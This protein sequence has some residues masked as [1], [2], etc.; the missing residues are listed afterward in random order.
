M[1]LD[2][3]HLPRDVL[4]RKLGGI[5]EIY[6][7]F[8]GVD[9]RREAMKIFPAVH[10]SMGGLW[11]DYERAASGG[12]RVGSPRNHQTNV[13]GIFAIGE[14][15]YQY[16]GAN[17][18]GANS[19]VACIFSGLVV[20]P[21]IVA[22]LD[23]LPRGSAAEQPSALF[24]RAFREHQARYKQLLARGGDGENPYLL[25]QQLGRV[26]TGAAMSPLKIQDKSELAPRRLAPWYW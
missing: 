25:H 17:R 7:K 2:V 20:A 21:G 9:P 22:A 12:L 6:E 1:Y 24:D 5:L 8:Q 4:E 18:L 10:Y 14:C 26:M 16:H 19:L 13:P 3:S 23:S 15:D 11:V